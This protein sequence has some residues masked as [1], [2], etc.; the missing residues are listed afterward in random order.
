MHAGQASRSAVAVNALIYRPP[1]AL[2][3][4]TGGALTA[5]AAAAAAI[6]V[7]LAVGA[8]AEFRTFLAWAAAAALGALALVFAH[9]TYSVA[10]LAY[11]I[12]RDALTITWGFRQVIVP[13]ENIQRMVPGWRIDAPRVEGVNWW[14][15]HIGVAEMPRIGY[16]LFYATLD[17]PDHLLYIV[18]DAEAYAL[19]VLEQASFAEAIQA[20]AAL[21]P[22]GEPLVHRSVATGPAALPFWRDRAAMVT[23]GVAAVACGALGG[24]LFGS[25][26]ALPDVV[27]IRYPELGGVVRVG[28]RAELLRIAQA[29]FGIL[30]VNLVLGIL[31]H[32]RERAAGLWLFGAAA[33]LQ[34]VLLGAAV[35]AVQFA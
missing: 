23:T 5:W 32:A 7:Y 8:D 4:I 19:T 11:V 27:E 10:T 9:W 1:R 17:T 12:T 24:F 2:G 26:P 34:V 35:L 3:I 28:D 15:C 29:G 16:T 18:T 21:E 6:C 14:G 30:V 31:V 13:L 33:I 22:T 20:R 25:Y